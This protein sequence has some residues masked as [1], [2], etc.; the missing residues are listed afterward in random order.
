MEALQGFLLKL[1]VDSLSSMR[2]D[3]LACFFP[4]QAVYA[5]TK[6]KLVIDI[7]YVSS[8]GG[9][10]NWYRRVQTYSELLDMST[11]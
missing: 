8:W 2:I 9:L 11:A 10:Q 7:Y 5:A 4:L 1:P 3:S 6:K